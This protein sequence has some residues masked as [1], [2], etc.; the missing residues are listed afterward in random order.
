MTVP[1]NLPHLLEIGFEVLSI[2]A[3]IIVILLA[4]RIGPMLTLSA[5]RRVAASA[6]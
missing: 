4:L 5:H 6:A 3:G 2:A 1:P